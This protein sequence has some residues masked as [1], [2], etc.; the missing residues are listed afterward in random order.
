[1]RYTILLLKTAMYNLCY[2]YSPFPLLQ[3]NNNIFVSDA[4]KV[5]SFEK[6]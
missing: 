1:M 3:I 2:F 6:T 5:P 4:Y